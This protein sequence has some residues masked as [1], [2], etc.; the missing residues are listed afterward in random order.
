MNA[1][2]TRFA[3]A[4]MVL[5]AIGPAMADL[6]GPHSVDLATGLFDQFDPTLGTLDAAIFSVDSSSS[7]SIFL[8]SQDVGD[9]SG[10]AFVHVHI[11]QT[12]AVF[13][14]SF[15][16]YTLSTEPYAE[17]IFEGAEVSLTGPPILINDSQSSTEPGLLLELTGFGLTME[18]ENGSS[19]GVVFDTE[20]VYELNSFSYGTVVSSMSV[21]YSYTPTPEPLSFVGLSF[22]LLTFLG[23]RKARLS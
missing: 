16:A 9:P 15:Q 1:F 12:F 10:Q 3:A 5:G 18:Q 20:P 7:A 4:T 23:R 14:S 6:S 22:G 2:R 19:N 8:K 13:V 11:P 17:G 21:T